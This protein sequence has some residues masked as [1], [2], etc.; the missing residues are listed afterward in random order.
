MDTFTISRNQIKQIILL[1]GMV[2]LSVISYSQ[3]SI[4]SILTKLDPQKW[5]ASI[6]KRAEKLEDKIV[7]KTEKT[8]NR[9]KQ[10]EEKIYSRMLHTKDSL[11]AKAALTGIQEKYQSFRNKLKSP[12]VS[13]NTGQYIAKLDTLKTALKFLDNNHITGNVQDALAKTSS[14]Q[15]KFGQAEAIKQFIKERRQQLKEQLERIGLLKEL[16]KFNKEVYY[17]SAQINEY[18][19][20]LKDSKKTERKALEL[21]SKTKLFKDFMRKNSQLASL[22]RLPTD[23]N[24]PSTQASLAGL[25]TRAQVNNL[26]QQQIAAGGPGAQQQFSQNLQAAQSQLQQL[27]GQIGKFGGNSSDDIM[28]E[29][30]KP[31]NEKTKN[32][33]RRLEYGTNLQTQ[34]ATNFFPVTSDIGLSLGYKLNGKSIIGIGASYKMGWGRGWN[35]LRISHQGLGLRSYAD[36]KLKGSLWIS[37]GY[38]QNYK[39]SFSEFSQLQDRSAW[40]QSGLIGVSKVI[41]MKTKFFKKT[42]LQLLWDFLS[43]EQVPLTQPLV[44]RIGYNF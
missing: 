13:V 15:D 1:G 40:Q 17:Y 23:P 19:E 36:I 33:W 32:F 27:K 30:F 41:S 39:S 29:G 4:D 35:N 12:L 38:E 44:F 3:S 22:F 20:I 11:Q 8:L 25:Q 2:L 42:K 10:Q 24:D 34:K 26:I 43:Y 28:P 6:S 5:T 14:L 9:L 31:N 7:D 16:K 37:G 21:L 18:R